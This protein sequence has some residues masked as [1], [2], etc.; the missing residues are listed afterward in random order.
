MAK[1]RIKDL[2]K[3]AN[4]S[5]AEMRRVLGGIDPEPILKQGIIGTN[6]LTPRGAS[7]YVIQQQADQ[8][9]RFKGW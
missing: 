6:P 4:I 9:A 1:V 7:P 5:D 8:I 2:P 3:N